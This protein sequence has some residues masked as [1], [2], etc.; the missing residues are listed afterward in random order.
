MYKREIYDL[1]SGYN[2]NLKIADDWDLYLQIEE[3]SHQIGWT[4]SRPLLAY[5]QVESSLSNAVNKKKFQRERNSVRRTA[6]KRRNANNI[7]LIGK[8]FDL[9][10]T[11][12]FN[13]KILFFCDDLVKTSLQIIKSTFCN[14]SLI[15]LLL[16]KIIFFF[17]YKYL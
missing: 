3:R 1:T 7:L 8:Y 11:K 5:R 17:I 2:E 10:L 4:G 6:L 13:I 15:R 16:K 9:D 12:F 14:V